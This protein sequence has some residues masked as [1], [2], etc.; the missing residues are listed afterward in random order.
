[1]RIANIDK[2]LCLIELTQIIAAKNKLI[3][4]VMTA[5][6]IF[7][8]VFQKNFAEIKNAQPKINSNA[9]YAPR[10]PV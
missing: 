5:I 6:Y 2:N 4:D 9:R 1:L 10:Q 8:Y 3:A 7:L